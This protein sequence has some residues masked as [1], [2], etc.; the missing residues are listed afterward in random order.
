[1]FVGWVGQSFGDK[2]QVGSILESLEKVE[3]LSRHNGGDLLATPTEG[4]AL[5]PIGRSVDQVG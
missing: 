1:L 2:P 4:Y 3:I 5:P